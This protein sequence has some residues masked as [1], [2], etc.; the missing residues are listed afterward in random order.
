MT[1]SVPIDGSS[2]LGNGDDEYRQNTILKEECLPEQII[3]QINDINEDLD[4]H[5]FRTSYSLGY[6]NVVLDDANNAKP[7][8]IY[9]IDNTLNEFYPK[10]LP[11][12]TTGFLVCV[13]S[14]AKNYEQYFTSQYI[15]DEQLKLLWFRKI[16]NNNKTITYGEWKKPDGGVGLYNTSFFNYPQNLVNNQRIVKNAYI[17]GK[18]GGYGVKDGWDFIIFPVTPDNKY[19]IKGITKC[20]YAFF[21]SVDITISNYISGNTVLPEKPI[22]APA[23]AKC[24]TVSFRDEESGDLWINTDNVDYFPPKLKEKFIPK[25]KEYIRVEKDGSGDY[26]KLIDAPAYGMEHKNTTI[27]LGAGDF[28]LIEEH[29]SQYFEDFVFTNYTNMGPMIGNGTHLICS[30]KSRILCNYTGDNDEVKKGYSPLN[31]C[32]TNTFGIGDFVIEGATIIASN[33]RYCV[34]DDVGIQVVPYKHEYIRC[35]MY[36]DNSNRSFEG[37][38]VH[39]H[40]CI[41]GGMGIAGTIVVKDCIFDGVGDAD[42]IAVA[43]HNDNYTQQPMG[44]I[45]IEGNYF[46]GNNTVEIKSISQYTEKTPVIL[47]NNSLGSNYVYG[48]WGGSTAPDNMEV[49]AWGNEIRSN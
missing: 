36:L 30:P 43:W 47:R 21:S 25:T 26:T 49:L 38:T 29:G 31:P 45:V 35:N 17:D 6:A 41:G 5:Y 14:Q 4:E 13:T 22:V 44:Y 11:V 48:N 32:A 46:R 42:N 19:Q 9:K 3:A 40:R 8:M 1:V 33:V 7:N 39:T 34:H 12:T 18:S 15:L 2:W 23:N 16:R 37:I 10:N 28:D 27:Y 20:H 24:L